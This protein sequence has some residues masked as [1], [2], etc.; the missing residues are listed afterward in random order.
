[1]NQ[2][3][4]SGE[5]LDLLGDSDDEGQG[6]GGGG[7]GRGREQRG[8]E[9]DVEE[10]EEDDGEQY[11]EADGEHE[12]EQEQE[13]EQ[14]H[15]GSEQGQAQGQAQGQREFDATVAAERLSLLRR[16]SAEMILRESGAAKEFKL[17]DML[18]H[19]LDQFDGL[20]DS[21]RQRRELIGEA[22]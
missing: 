13:H 7:G 6:Q 12:Y 16:S 20:I 19:Q 3:T 22:K 15:G 4:Q 18:A 21:V 5:F 9:E 1:M 14:E 10:E 2:S 11:F 17:N 8:G